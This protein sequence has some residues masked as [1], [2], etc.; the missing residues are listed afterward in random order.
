MCK[1]GMLPHFIAE[2]NEAKALKMIISKYY[3]YMEI[4]APE[5][6]HTLILAK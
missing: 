4:A 5:S 3:C 6:N 2:K 1:L